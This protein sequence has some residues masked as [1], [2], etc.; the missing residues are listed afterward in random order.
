MVAR[1]AQALYRRGLDVAIWG[2]STAEPGVVVETEAPVRSLGLTKYAAHGRTT[3]SLAREL[4]AYAPDIL[5]IH[6]YTTHVHGVRAAQRVGIHRVIVSFH[7]FRLGWH[8]IWVCRHLKRHVDRVI[9]LNEA[10]RQLYQEACGYSDEQIYVLPN[11]VDVE[12]FSPRP[13]EVR[14]AAQWNL[15]PDHFVIGSVGGLNRNKGHRFLIEAFSR[16]L[17]HLPQARLLLVGE[18]RHRR[19]LEDLAHRL[20]LG[21]KVVFAGH[22]RDTPRWLSLFDVFVQPSVIESDPLAVHEAMAMGL[23]IVATNRGGLPELLAE[24]EAGVLVPPGQPGALA[25]AILELAADPPRARALGEQARR[26]AVE[27][28]D[29]RDYERRLWEL[30]QSLLAK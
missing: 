24:G 9:L 29:L 16:L 13:R 15:G 5:H 3:R 12:R 25:E 10:M 20:A 18:G 4:A 6:S 26:R 22:Q 8:R 17:P 21:D 27:R 28:Y 11:A 7:D 30:Y 23:P 14:L 19:R 2:I 1:Q